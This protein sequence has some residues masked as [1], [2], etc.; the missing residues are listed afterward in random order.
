MKGYNQAPVQTEQLKTTY[1][2]RTPV[3]IHSHPDRARRP[4]SNPPSPWR[5]PVSYCC[6]PTWPDLATAKTCCNK[7]TVSG[8]GDWANG[9]YRMEEGRLTNSR[10]YTFRRSGENFVIHSSD[11]DPKYISPDVPNI[12]CAEDIGRI[13]FKLYEIRRFKDVT[14][15]KD[16]SCP[17]A[18]TTAAPTT[19]TAAPATTSNTCPP[20]RNVMTGPLKGNYKHA[21]SGDDRCTYDGCL[22]TKDNEEY[23]FQTG[24]DTVQEV[25]PT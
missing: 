1:A 24:T 17:G 3:S 15:T 9:D 19:T 23:C 11:G 12:L 25:C 5:S 10:G 16:P 4:L 2:V 13:K 20:C 6:L 14:I 8:L 18:K 21:G 7:L 22:Y